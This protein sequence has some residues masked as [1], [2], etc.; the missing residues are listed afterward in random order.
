MHRHTHT[1]TQRH[2]LPFGIQDWG[3][4][5]VTDRKIFCSSQ[6]KLQKFTL[7]KDLCKVCGL[8]NV[9]IWYVECVCKVWSVKDVCRVCVGCVGGV[10]GVCRACPSERACLISLSVTRSNSA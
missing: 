5:C 10:W 4:Q 9:C 3:P 1:H 6:R 7:L 8:C 2:R